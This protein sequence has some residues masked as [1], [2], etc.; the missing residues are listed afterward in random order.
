[1]P[2]EYSQS[3]GALKLNNTIVARGYSGIGIGKNKPENEA[4]HNIG[5]IPRGTYSIGKPFHHA[6]TGA[7]TMRLIPIKG[8]NVYGRTGF[9]I[10]GDSASHPGE[11]SNGCIIVKL[12]SRQRIWNSHDHIITVSR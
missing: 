10:H 7:Y 1:M 11:A 8:T 4:V 3:T 6:H 2:W 12:D 5:P 9:M